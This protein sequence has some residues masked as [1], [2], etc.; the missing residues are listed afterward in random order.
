M[1]RIVPAVIKTTLSIFVVSNAP[2]CINDNA[3][4]IAL[5]KTK[6]HV[7]VDAWILLKPLYQVVTYKNS[8]SEVNRTQ[9]KPAADSFPK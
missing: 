1:S 7:A 9:P 3:V 4:V 5:P 2:V 8:K 6:M